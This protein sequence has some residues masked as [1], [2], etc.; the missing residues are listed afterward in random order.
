MAQFKQKNWGKFEGDNVKNMKN[1]EGRLK[2]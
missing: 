1:A 2:G